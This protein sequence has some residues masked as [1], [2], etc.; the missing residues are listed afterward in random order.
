[1][2]KKYANMQTK[3]I[4]ITGP[5]STGKSELTKKLAYYFSMPF[6]H[7]IAREYVENLNRKYTKNDVIEIAKLQIE[8][9][10][11]LVAQN[12]E[13]LF[14]DTDLII[15]KIWL[16]HVYGDYPKWIDEKLKSTPRY[17]HLLC[18]YDLEWVYDP[19]RENSNLREYFFSIYMNEIEKLKLNYYVIKG[20]GDVRW[21]SAI[22]I[23]ENDYMM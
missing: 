17:C 7:E 14:I 18:Y 1:M 12:P 9:E 21:K 23:I 8:K 3:R 11:T 10:E 22:N 4:V 5:E 19:V 6:I 16:L 2:E 15:T 20:H 13:Y